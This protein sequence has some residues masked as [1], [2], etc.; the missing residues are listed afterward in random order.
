M[1][2][3]V[4]G[5]LF[6][7]AMGEVNRTLADY[8]AVSKRSIPE[9]VAQKGGQI[10]LGNRGGQFGPAFP[11]LYE[12]LSD[13]APAEGSITEDRQRALDAAGRGSARPVKVRQ[14][15]I[16]RAE[17]MLAGRDSGLVTMVPVNGTSRFI[18]REVRFTKSNPAKQIRNRSNRGGVVRINR[19]SE[20]SGPNQ[21]LL[22]KIALAIAI[23]LSIRETGRG[24]AAIAFLPKAY[25]R[26]ISGIRREGRARA[27]DI[28]AAISDPV[29]G[30]TLSSSQR[31]ASG[32]DLGRLSYRA[33]GTGAAMR[34][35]GFVPASNT[36][37]AQDKV[38]TVLMMVAADM[39]AYVRRKLDPHGDQLM[40][41]LGAIN[42]KGGG[43]RR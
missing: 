36:P 23:E 15:A 13:L 30:Q 31:N 18:V 1:Q 3:L 35:E 8:I 10:I 38:A 6:A 39:R 21:K 20:A 42:S 43:A 33:Q 2:P 27:K 14:R 5:S 41:D 28:A 22:N 24:Y 4:S 12:V 25:R 19:R 17:S 7:P 11:G 34:I 29:P 37:E 16:D 40:L 9:I 32:W 26:V